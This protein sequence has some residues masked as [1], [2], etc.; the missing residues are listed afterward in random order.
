MQV[1][2][3]HLGFKPDDSIKHAVIWGD[4]SYDSFQIVDL[5]FEGYNEKHANPKTNLVVY[6]GKL[7][8][9]AY[10][11]GEY[12]IADFSDFKAP[13]IYL[14]SL[15]NEHNS[16]PFEIREDVYSR[17]LRKAFDYIHIQRCGQAVPDYHEACHLDD[18]VERE[19]GKYFD[20]TGGWH[21]AGD[22]RKW[23][24]HTLLLGISIAQLKRHKNP[25]WF[26]F[27]QNEGD[28]L[29]E[30]RWG[31]TYFLKMQDED[32]LIWHDVGGGLNGD[33]SDN[34]WT[35]NIILSGDERHVS[36][37]YLPTVQWRFIMF[38]AMLA[39]I[40]KKADPRYS[41]QCF[42]AALKT[43]TY[44]RSQPN[45]QI[46]AV[47]WSV[48]AL[49]ELCRLSP[50]P[51]L[52]KKLETEICNLLSFQENEFKF[53]QNKIRGYWYTDS[54][55]NDLYRWH[56]GSGAPIIA[57]SEAYSF[58]GEDHELG[59][60]CHKALTLYCRDY[61]LPMT[62]TN[63]FSM[64]PYGLYTHE[65]SSEKYRPLDGTLKFRFFSPTKCGFYQ[66]LT[67]HLLSHAVGLIMAGKI[68]KDEKIVDLSRHQVEWVMGCNPQ[69][70]CLMTAEGINNPYPHSRFLG[71]IPGGIM[72]GF[73]GDENDE[74]VLDMRYTTDWRTTEYW[75]PHTC[76][77]IWYVSLMG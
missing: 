51:A 28:L 16:V 37:K 55:K 69:N 8:K 43:Y 4:G 24:Q 47:A 64:I 65:P 5:G 7:L 58:L 52:N 74:P 1:C 9:K 68:I 67:A 62:Q 21:D 73:I 32:G 33:N 44:M 6:K 20:T 11:W 72:N 18:A 63:P 53:D 2:V 40:F 36:K 34:R 17:T 19:S 76:F 70:S 54:G 38:E 29:D 10:Q 60:A 71:L 66:G 77:Y 56:E 26:T 30:L 23:V 25:D 3:N 57:V 14:I 49:I 41:D 15:D 39:E 31:N 59:K 61:V 48:L 46:N 35:D 22:L 45:L 75:S 27:N 13:G 42:E 50:E 12:Y